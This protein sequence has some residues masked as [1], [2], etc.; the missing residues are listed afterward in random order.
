[1]HKRTKTLV[2][3][4][5]L[6]LALG[7]G[8]AATVSG[9]ATAGQA[10]SEAALSAKARTLV[11]EFGKPAA[12]TDR[13]PEDIDPAQ[14]GDGGLDK[15]T[16]RLIAETDATDVWTALDIHGNICVI[17]QTAG[18]AGTACT[19]ADRFATSGVGITLSSPSDYAEVYLVPSGLQIA[20]LPSGLE[21][22]APTLIVGDSR[23][24]D[25]TAITFSGSET[26]RGAAVDIPLLRPAP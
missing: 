5:M 6:G 20:D 13:L 9:V 23:G 25:A 8:V 12:S 22:V 11:P 18:T 7:V 2:T 21:Q 14:A 24:S 1:M 10:D 16:T 26:A 17:S 15:S 19:P 4:G 3:A